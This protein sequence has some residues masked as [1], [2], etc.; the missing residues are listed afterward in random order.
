[1]KL[2]ECLK[3]TNNPNIYL[4]PNAKPYGYQCQTI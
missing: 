4:K 1:M 2:H 3:Q